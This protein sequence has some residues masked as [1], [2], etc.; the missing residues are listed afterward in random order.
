MIH[1]IITSYKEIKSTE[2]AINAFLNQD[3]PK[4]FKIVVVDPFPEVRN[5]IKEKF[6]N[7]VEFFLDPG[8]GKSYALNL[9]LN[10]IYT[11]NPD[12]III[13]T[14]GDVYVNNIAIKEILE[15]F[16]DK[17][18]GAVTGRPISL[19]PRNNIT[20]YFSHL[21]LDAGAHKIR[22]LRVKKN[23]FMECSGYLFAFRNLLK[24]FPLD[25]AEDS[26]IPYLIWKKGYRVGYAKNAEVYVNFPNTIKDFI[27]QKK[28]AGVGSHS[29][30]KYYAK[31]FPKVKT[32]KNEVRYGTLWALSYPKNIKEFFWTF[33]LF[34]L[35]LYIWLSYYYDAKFKKKTYQDGWR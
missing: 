26:I 31:D 34:P 1:I 20:G 19:N 29:K 8:E 25:V 6:Q 35:R 30:L 27:N 12:D 14:D 24:E 28:R 21:L 10:D 32:F 15:K 11:G 3:I 33:S 23:E 9:L 22:L 4:P 7:K 5:F 2:R 17:E 18:I 16:K 13:S